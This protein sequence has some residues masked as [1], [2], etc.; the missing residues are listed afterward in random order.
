MRGVKNSNRGKG[1]H[2]RGL[3]A[4]GAARGGRAE[5]HAVAEIHGR[6]PADGPRDSAHRQ[7]AVRY[8]E[9]V[10]R[11]PHR[12]FFPRLNRSVVGNSEQLARTET[13]VDDTQHAVDL[14][15]RVLRCVT[16]CMCSARACPVVVV[17][18]E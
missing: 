10:C 18:S 13:A 2:G 6:G 1:K 9:D 14:S 4:A 5:A 7:H 3:E 15:K 17:L 11:N 16:V 12:M 8:E